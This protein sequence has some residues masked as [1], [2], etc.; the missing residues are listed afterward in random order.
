MTLGKRV[1]DLAVGV[2][3]AVALTPVASAVAVAVF[4]TSG[5]PVV[6]NQT[7]VGAN[8][9][10]F[11]CVKFRTMR[12]GVPVVAKALLERDATLYTPL[13]PFLRN[14][15]LDE[16]PQLWNVLRGEM[17][18]VGPRPALPSQEDL[19]NLR[20]GHGITPLRP[21]MTG[22]AQVLGRESLTLS[23][24]VRAEAL[25]ARRTSLR[26]DLGIMLWT[27][28]AVLRGRGAF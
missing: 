20:R 22:L 23:T 24:K 1:L 14:T 7:R 17:S 12:V 4:L 27:V 16:L 21:G 25:Y 3:L 15:S 6:I 11:A 26:L 2:P 9:R 13:G 19:L 28:R 8:E 18:L 5:W 10:P